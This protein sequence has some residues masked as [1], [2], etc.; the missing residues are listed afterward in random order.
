MADVEVTRVEKT[1]PS[2]DRITHLGGRMWLWT[3]AEVVAAIEDKSNAF[4]V[5]VGG[6]KA[7]LGVVQG[8]H[9]KY[10]RSHANAKWTDNLLALPANAA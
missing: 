1:G 3:V 9:A 5:M 4:Y 8:P 6:Q 10:V 7:Y 2:H